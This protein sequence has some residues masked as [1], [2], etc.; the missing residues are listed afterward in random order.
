MKY[1]DFTEEVAA[2]SVELIHRLTNIPLT[3]IRNAKYDR[4]ALPLKIIK[5]TD[6]EGFER[7]KE[8]PYK[9]T[10]LFA[11][12]GIE[13]NEDGVVATEVKGGVAYAQYNFNLKV[14]IY[15]EDSS[16]A[17][18]TG[19]VK[20]YDPTVMEWMRSP[21][22][23]MAFTKIPRTAEP[24]DTM[25][26]EEWWIIR[27]LLFKLNVSVTLTSMGTP[28]AIMSF[29]VPAMINPDGGNLTHIG[30]PPIEFLNKAEILD[31]LESK[32]DKE[33]GARLFYNSEGE[34][35]A[36][37]IIDGDGTRGLFDDGE[38][39]TIVTH[40]Q[41][42]ELHD[43]L[44][45]IRGAFVYIGSI[46]STTD[47]ITDNP[48]LLTSRALELKNVLEVGHTLID[49]DSVEWYY[50]GDGWNDMGRGAMSIVTTE[51]AGLMSKFDKQTL[52]QLQIS[53]GLHKVDYENPHNVTKAQVGLSNVENKSSS[54][55][56]SEIT[57]GHIPIL[58]Q[59]KI[60][61]LIDDLKDRYTKD[62]IETLV[63][64]GGIF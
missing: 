46:S 55:I 39:K 23:G 45:A 56:L 14:V 59:S 50:D 10:E 32:V 49:L 41:I 51:N 27:R 57:V 21:S 43:R 33:T 25:I 8:V 40:A 1:Q 29:S 30:M 42:Q 35:V 11:V 15:G 16:R 9:K 12:F 13:D 3:D 37:L 63:M 20:A 17:A 2:L 47:Q 44:D 28:E 19:I 24:V 53:F 31:L 4:G 52:D 62:E 7:V 61:N 48:S 36:K 34:K 58:P 5:W 6:A 54:D 38:Y 60:Q 18:N 22:V 26:N 64:D